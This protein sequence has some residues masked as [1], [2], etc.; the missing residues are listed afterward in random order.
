M[1]RLW[2]IKPGLS[3]R[4]R[5]GEYQVAF[6]GAATSG[7]AAKE[8]NCSHAFLSSVLHGVYYQRWH[9]PSSCLQT[10]LR[11]SWV[12]AATASPTVIKVLPIICLCIS[13]L[14]LWVTRSRCKQCVVCSVVQSLLIDCGTFETLRGEPGSSDRLE[15]GSA[16]SLGFLFS[17]AMS[18]SCH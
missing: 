2:I 11:A 3:Q 15:L 5:C 18:L 14:R 6:A 9:T 16:A 8:M 1:K 4:V 10:I 12:S 17:Y 7:T 13:V